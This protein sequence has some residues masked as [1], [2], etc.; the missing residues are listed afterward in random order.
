MS[1]LHTGASKED[2]TKHY[3]VSV[4]WDTPGR[5]SLDSMPLGNGD[6]GLNV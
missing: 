6:I 4:V 1:A 2:V 3:P 5:S